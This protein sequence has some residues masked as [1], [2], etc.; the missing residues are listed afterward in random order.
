MTEAHI[1]MRT[2]HMSTKI[3]QGHVIEVAESAVW[4]D[5]TDEVIVLQV[6]SGVYFGLKGVGC[7]LWHYIQAPRSL[8]AILDHLTSRYTV[9]KEVCEGQTLAFL[10]ELARHELILVRSHE[11]A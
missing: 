4:C 5:L 10:E 8:E 2:Q 1:K 7:A 9:E 11:A 3:Q 6:A